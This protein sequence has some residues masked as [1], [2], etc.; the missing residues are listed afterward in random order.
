MFMLKRRSRQVS[1]E[2]LTLVEHLAELRTRIIISIL[3]LAVGVVVGFYYSSPLGVY[4]L[5]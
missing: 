2:G 3:T 5:G 4:N 1:A